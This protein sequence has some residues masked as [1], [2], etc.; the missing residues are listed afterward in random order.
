[1]TPE[2]VLQ[3]SSLLCIVK[4]SYSTPCLFLAL[5]LV[6]LCRSVTAHEI[7]LIIVARRN[8]YGLPECCA[9]KQYSCNSM[10]FAAFTMSPRMNSQKGLVRWY[11]VL[12]NIYVGRSKIEWFIFSERCENWWNCNDIE[13]SVCKKVSQ[14]T[15]NLSNIY[16]SR[17]ASLINRVVKSVGSQRMGATKQSLGYELLLFISVSSHPNTVKYW[18]CSVILILI[19]HFWFKCIF[20]GRWYT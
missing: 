5:W 11:V 16:N 8:F 19:S 9:M 15:M 14:V 12:Y 7:L 20:K 6:V 13:R 17:A 18:K 4:V 3:V 1:M 2:F 10:A